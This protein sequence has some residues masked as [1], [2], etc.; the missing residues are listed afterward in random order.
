MPTFTVLRRVDAFIDYTAEVEA[1]TAEEAAELARQKGDALQ[2]KKDGEHEC[3]ARAFITLD[4]NGNEIG[5]TECGD[6]A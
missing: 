1:P 2:W 5:G 6:F 4:A 3:D